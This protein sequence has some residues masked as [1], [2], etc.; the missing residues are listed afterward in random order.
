MEKNFLIVIGRLNEAKVI[1]QCGNKSMQSLGIGGVTVE[2]SDGD[3]A[4]VAGS[5]HFVN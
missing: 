3:C 1:F 4:L 5:F 2:D